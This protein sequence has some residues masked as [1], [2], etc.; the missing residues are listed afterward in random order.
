MSYQLNEIADYIGGEVIGDG[1]LL[2]STVSPLEAI[3]DNAIVM[4]KDKAS[5]AI[6]E[7]S[8]ALA[9]IVPKAFHT[10]KKPLIKVDNPAIALIKLLTLFT[11]K[12]ETTPT[13]H[14]TATFEENVKLG[15]ALSIGPYVTIDKE[16]TIGDN[17]DIKAHVTIGK[18]VQIGKH[19]TLHP[20]VVIYDNTVIQ[21]YVT[22]HAS[23]VIGSDGFGYEFDGEKHLKMPHLGHVVIEAHV[24]IGANSVV[25]SATLGHTTIGK[26]TKIDNLVQIAHNVTIGEHNILC[27][28]TGIAG[29]TKTGNHVIC[30]ADVGIADHVEI[31]NQ[32]VLGPRTGVAAKKK[33]PDGSVWLGNPA[34]PAKQTI[35]QTTMLNRLPVLKKTVQDLVKRVKKL[36]KEETV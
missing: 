21:D 5:L 29:S 10:D 18:N 33:C 1:T 3:K 19:V 28:F 27:A 6:A 11:P 15:D 20:H 26:G 22:I 30:A 7:D 35:Q 32:V 34:R 24:E 17:A 12:S 13:I 4:S 23:S 25:D 14:K 36:E 9:I 16:T 2:I 8:N 31:G